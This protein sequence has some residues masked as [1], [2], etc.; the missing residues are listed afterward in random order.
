VLP[1]VSVITPTYN[2][3]HLLPETLDS[4]LSQPFD[5]LEYLLVDDGSTDDTAALARRYGNRI[6][7]FHHANS[8]EAASVNRGWQQANGRYVAIVSSDDPMLPGWLEHSVA[9][10]DA[11]P[12]VLVCY[13]DWNIIDGDSRQLST[14]KTFDY[15]LESMVGWF[16]TIPGPGALIR[17]APLS[18]LERLRDPR[19]RYI[20]DLESWLTLGLI[21]R[22]A[23]IP[24]ALATWRQHE[25]SITVADRSLRRAE[26]FIE[27]ATSFFRRPDLPSS[28]HALRVSA[29]S[30]AH[31]YASWVLQDTAPVRSALHLRRSYALMPDE[32]PD[33]PP[34]LRRFARPSVRDVLH[35]M[36]RTVG[37]GQD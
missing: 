16:N 13:P 23:R 32:P 2:R 21:G 4:I 1:S 19:Y 34:P 22:F 10:M 3:A 27:L 20:P 37:C 6:R 24:T 18:H 11:H 26:E 29:L 30:R 17:R 31:W 12:D 14:V 9:F 7:Y 8:G 33:L 36:R 35:A 15:T 25:G 5:D 28:L